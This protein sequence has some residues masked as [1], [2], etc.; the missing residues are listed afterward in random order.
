MTDALVGATLAGKYR[1]KRAIGAGG[2]GAVY[3]GEHIEIGKRVAIKVMGSRF[4]AHPEMAER[5]R[6][7]ARAAS[8]VESDHIV[9]VFDVGQDADAGLYMVM[10]YL[11][12]EDLQHRLESLGGPLPVAD[13]LDVGLQAAR[14]LAKAHAA[15]VVHR[16]LKPANLFLTTREDGTTHLK[17]L[18]FGISKLMRDEPK[19]EEGPKGLTREGSVIGTPQYMS[20]EQAKG[21]AV[22]HATDIWSLGAVLYEALAGVGAYQ[23]KESYELTIIQIVTTSA[24]PLSEI[25][26]WVP[27]EVADV[28]HNA[29]QHAKGMRLPDMGTFASQLKEAARITKDRVVV[30]PDPSRPSLSRSEVHSDTARLPTGAGLVVSRAT[31]EPEGTATGAAPKAPSRFKWAMA[32][33]GAALVAIAM[34]VIA[35]GARKT[36]VGP[37]AAAASPPPPTETPTAQA[38]PAVP[39]LTPLSLA[40]AET[41]TATAPPPSAS[42]KPATGHAVNARPPAKAAPSAAVKA[43]GQYGGAGVSTTY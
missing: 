40:P 27:A 28:V 31:S 36:P 19:T 30:R 25:A 26:P 34:A 11:V 6:R 32:A 33:G 10:E 37:E 38:A 8:A 4:A 9:Q 15:G 43:N 16:D 41:A 29:L 39:S 2:M 1:V 42:A 20:P 24:A 18:D 12:G 13:A 35:M 3:E 17:I 21:I 22:D 23:E 7:E 5:F 14:A